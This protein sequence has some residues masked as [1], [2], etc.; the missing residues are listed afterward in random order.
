MN[1]VDVRYVDNCS[2]DL[3]VIMTDAA[4]ICVGDLLPLLLGP[5]LTSQT[6]LVV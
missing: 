3:L 5:E 4:A 1:S 6:R 2:N